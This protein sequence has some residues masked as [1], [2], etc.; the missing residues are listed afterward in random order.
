MSFDTTSQKTHAVGRNIGT[1]RLWWII[2]GYL[3]YFVGN[4]AGLPQATQFNIQR[5]EIEGATVFPVAELMPLVSGLTNGLV[6][7]LDIEAARVALTLKYVSSNYV[8]SG[9]VIDTKPNDDGVLRVRIVEGRL[10]EV[11]V[12]GNRYF[13]ESFYQRRLDGIRKNPLQASALRDELQLWRSIYPLERVNGE[14]RPGVKPGDGVLDLRVQEAFPYHLG[15]EYAN[16]RPPTTGA[17][18]VKVLAR[19]DSLTLNGDVTWVNY[20]VVRGES[21]GIQDSVWRGLGDLS[22]GY[23][24]PVTSHDTTL[25]ANYGRS[26]ASVIEARFEDLDIESESEIYG[27]SITHPLRRSHRGEW[28]V[29]FGAERK[30]IRTSVLGVPYSLSPGAIDGRSADSL[31]RASSEWSRRGRTYAFNAR[32]TMNV[33]VDLLDAT[34]HAD[35]PDGQFV[36]WVVQSRYIRKL[37]SP[38]LEWVLRAFCQYTPD[39]LLSMEQLA[40]GG[41]GSVRGYRENSLVRD[42]GVFGGMELNWIVWRTSEGLPRVRLVPFVASGAG[43]MTEGSTPEP[44]EISSAGM[45]VVVNAFKRI[46]ASLFWGHAFRTMRYGEQDP[47][48]DGIHFRI[49]TWAF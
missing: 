21:F 31:L 14:L 7:A 28:S 44:T 33:G 38:D 42:N 20:G 27:V 4:A 32:L 35:A 48:D 18:Q 5:V 30:Q 37:W 16:D 12:Q 13:R 43:W 40:V 8:N 47:Q 19:A 49:S 2:L 23:S 46:E 24:I 17:E 25:A 9:A 41:T 29:S 36:S 22:A 34:R 15:L 39:S 6:T 1:R 45:G 3:G 10:T 11:R 26:S